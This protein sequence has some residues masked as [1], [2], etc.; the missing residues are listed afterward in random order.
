MPPPVISWI[1]SIGSVSMALTVCVAPISLAYSSLE[2]S[3]ST[4]IK[5][6]ASR[7]LA[8]MSAEVPTPPMP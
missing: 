4:A 8:M 3:I 5:G 1:A 6:Y 7:M 2:S